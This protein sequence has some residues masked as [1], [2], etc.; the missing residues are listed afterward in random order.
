MSATNFRCVKTSSSKVVEQS[1][2]CEITEEYRTE[3]ISFHLK[4]W[5]KLTS[6]LWHQR[7][8]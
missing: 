8:C 2:S 6:P 4:C 5:L 1:I 3:S 7:A